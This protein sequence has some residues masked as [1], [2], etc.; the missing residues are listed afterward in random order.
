MTQPIY[1]KL[2]IRWMEQVK[3]QQQEAKE[4]IRTAED[5]VTACQGA[6]DALRALYDEA[7]LD[8]HSQAIQD[9]GECPGCADCA[10]KEGDDATKD[11]VQAPQGQQDQ[12]GVKP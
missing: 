12:E 4:A 6:F 8:P 11:G 7:P 1:K 2:L 5:K 9:K 10:P 3:Q